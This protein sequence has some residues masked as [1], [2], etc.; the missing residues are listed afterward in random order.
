MIF[1]HAIRWRV[2]PLLRGYVRG[3]VFAGRTPTDEIL[4]LMTE[5]SPLIRKCRRHF[6]F[7]W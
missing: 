4:A 3:L 2:A 1:E 6:V 5:W 7:R